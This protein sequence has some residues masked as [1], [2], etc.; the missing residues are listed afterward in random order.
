MTVV[1]VGIEGSSLCKTENF[2]LVSVAQ[3]SILDFLPNF[4]ISA[5][6][7][8]PAQHTDAN[9]TSM[10]VAAKYLKGCSMVGAIL[11]RFHCLSAYLL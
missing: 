11:S 7:T 5:V 4:S 6:Y 3:T 2:A 10:N 8:M 9:D 1:P